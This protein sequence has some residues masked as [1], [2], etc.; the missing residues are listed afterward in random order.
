MTLSQILKSVALAALLCSPLPAPA[1]KALPETGPTPYDPHHDDYSFTEIDRFV[2]RHLVLDLD[3]DFKRRVLQGSATLHMRRVDPEARRV[4][5]DT[6][7]I[8]VTDASVTLPGS[9]EK[10]AA[11]FRFGDA[12]ELLGRALVVELPAGFDPEAGFELQIHYRTSPQASALQWLPASLTAGGEHPLMFSQSQAIHARSWVPLQDTPALRITYE[13]TIRTPADM[14]A[15]MSADNDP[16]T[17][18]DGEYHFE[19]PQPIPSY[20]LAIAAGNLAF[21]D[22]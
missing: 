8:T 20:L 9:S 5:L 13:A 1:V 11:E 14:L 21:E 18:R 16:E 10:Q 15:V 4:I 22:R 3:V 19:M 7:D 6:R 17:A 2:T 12:H